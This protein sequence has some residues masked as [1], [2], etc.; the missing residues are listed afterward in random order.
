MGFYLTA[1]RERFALSERLRDDFSV[2]LDFH[3]GTRDYRIADPRGRNDAD[4]EE[5]Q[6]GETCERRA[7][8]DALDS[9]ATGRDRETFYESFYERLY[10][11]RT[12]L[13]P[14]ARFCYTRAVTTN[15]RPPPSP[16]TPY[17][18]R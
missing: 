11:P 4:D 17:P 10:E 2:A 8:I 9:L 1:F 6:I 12:E 18:S 14:R 16:L 13:G 5:E 3:G 7:P 15:S